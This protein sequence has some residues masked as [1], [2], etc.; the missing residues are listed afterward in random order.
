[1]TIPAMSLL[2]LRT[3][4]GQVLEDIDN[5]DSGD[6]PIRSV[7]IELKYPNVT[8]AMT[9]VTDSNGTFTFD[10]PPDI[11]TI[12]QKTPSEFLSVRDIEGNNPDSI[13]IDTSTASSLR[14]EF[15]DEHPSPFPSSAP[16]TS[17]TAL[18]YFLW[19]RK[20]GLRLI[21]YKDGK[22]AH[23]NHTAVYQQLLIV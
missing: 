4:A 8:V 15:V 12:F 2:Q 16:T 23:P 17:R 21:L 9:T 5:N 14:N 11:Y 6:I 10:A 20:P 18:G 19:L 1:M 7:S 22:I 3:I 13:A